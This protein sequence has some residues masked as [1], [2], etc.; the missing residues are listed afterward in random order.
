MSKKFIQ[1]VRGTHD[2]YGEEMR[3]FT[4]I[5]RQMQDVAT[6]YGFT[7]MQT[8]VFE[9]S[10]VF[11]RSLGD[12]S[13]V[14]SKE[15]YTFMD[16]GG[17]SITLRPEF[18]AAIVRAFLSGG[19]TQQLPFKVSYN[20]AA[21]R[22]ERPQKGR[23]RQFHQ[24]GLECLGATEP[25]QDTEMIACAAQFLRQLNLEDDVTLE[26]NTLG[27]MESRHAYREALIAYFS[28]HKD[29]LSQESQLRLAKNPLRILD[30]K[31]PED[32]EVVASAPLFEAFM[33]PPSR[34]WFDEV[35]KGLDVLGV[36][37]AISPRLVRGLDYYTHTVFEFTTDKLGSQSTVLAGGR[38]NGLVQQMGGADIPGMGW[39]AGIERLMLLAQM[40]PESRDSQQIQVVIA[41]TD[42]SYH[43]HALKLADD[44]RNA[45]VR[46]EMIPHHNINKSLKKALN[47]H[48][49]HFI[50]MGEDE[51]THDRYLVKDLSSPYNTEEHSSKRK[52]STYSYSAI[53]EMLRAFVRQGSGDVDTRTYESKDNAS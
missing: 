17:E 46:A 48:A 10:E 1:P 47:M 50:V 38:Y 42:A 22:Y 40:Q 29:A 18:T 20:G 39:A 7:E 51:L 11:H 6:L 28:T 34:S 49:S 31:Q 5:I 21:F 33:T 35:C 14:V 13:D 37:Y 15:T 41:P 53:I 52:E 43:A 4:H 26:L 24:V 27:D 16:R 9:F 36:T 2:V 3:L 8:P 44:L 19:Y 45:Q 32:K 30:S 25:W 23:L 12:T